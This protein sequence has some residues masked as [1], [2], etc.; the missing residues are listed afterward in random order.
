[1]G[2]IKKVFFLIVLAW[3]MCTTVQ[4]EDSKP[5][6]DV[7]MAMAVSEQQ[8]ISGQVYITNV[9]RNRGSF[10]ICVDNLSNVELQYLDIAIWSGENGQDDVIW[11]KVYQNS[12]GF[13]TEDSV[14]N[15]NYSIGKY[16]VHV[17]AVTMD[18]SY[19]WIGSEE[20]EMSGT[21][22]DPQVL[23]SVEQDSYEVSIDEIML[24]GGILEVR[25]AV[26]SKINGQDDIRWYKAE[27][28]NARY[29]LNWNVLDHRGLG[30]YEVH[31]Y[32]LTM[33]GE[34]VC[35]GKTSFM[36]S[37]PQIGNVAVSNL[38]ENKGTFKVELKNISN[39]S[40]IKEVQIAVWSDVN[41]QDDIQWYNMEYTQESQKTFNVDIRNHKY[42]LGKYFVHVYF[43]DI[44]GM[45]YFAGSTSCEFAARLGE[46]QIHEMEGTKFLVEIQ[47]CS[48]PGG[49]KRVEVPI[50]SDADGQDDLRWYAAQR[51]SDGS[52]KVEFD[53]KDHKGTGFYKVQAYIIT[54]GGE[55][56]LA[57]NSGVTVNAPSADANIENYDAEEGVFSVN[58]SGLTNEKIVNKILIPVWSEENGQD[59]IVWY[60]AKRKENGQYQVNIDIEKHRYCLGI[61]NIHVYLR[62][63]TNCDYFVKELQLNVEVTP[64]ELSVIKNNEKDYTIELKDF[65]IPGGAKQIQFPVWSKVNGQDDIKWHVADRGIDGIYRYH[66]SLQEHKGLGE[67]FIHSYAKLPNGTLVYLGK[68]G[69]NTSEPTIGNITTEVTD[70]EGGI[71]QIK[72][73]GIENEM[74]IDKVMVPVWSDSSQ[75]DIVWYEAVK[76][77][78][79]DYVVNVN[80]G[81]HKYNCAIYH[82]HVYLKDITG[83]EHLVDMLEC[84]MRP[85]YSSFVAEDP[86]GTE[87]AV[88]LT[89]S[90]LR[91]P[92]GEKYVSFAVW[93]TDNN[94]N[95]VRWYSASRNEEGAYIASIK[96]SNHK[97]LGQYIVHAYCG[98]RGNADYFIGATTFEIAK[99]P[100][101]AAVNV[102]DVNGT[103]G[104]FNVTVTG[105]M[106]P[107]GIS[108]VKVPVWCASDQSDIV[109]YDANKLTEGVYSIK[110]SAA[111]HAHHFGEYKIH[112]YITMGNGI[113]TLSGNA[114]TVMEA[115]NYVYNMRIS[116]TQRE[117]GIMGAS[118]E[119]VQFP[120]WS[121]ANGQDDIIWYEGEN[122]GGGKWNTA[123][124]SSRH[125]NGGEYLTHVYLTSGG[126]VSQVG[127]TSYSLSWLPNDQQQMILRS[128]L[129]S[130]STPFLLLVNR[131]THKVGIFQGWT[132]NWRLIQYWD[133]SDGKSST[134]TVEGVFRVGSRGYY[135]DSGD[136]R[137]YW[138]TQFYGDY[139][140]HS[141]LYNK[142]NGALMDGRLGMGLSHGCVRLDINNAKWIYDT[143]PSGSTVVVY[144]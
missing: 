47:G 135:F 50:W 80:I 66:L 52:Y 87:S 27:E 116:D 84:D 67:Y 51:C 20:L 115:D 14:S 138:W 16:F 31:A 125:N 53:I 73:S 106:A 76:N 70:Y 1:M 5:L 103:S 9:D 100:Y 85:S 75:K 40:L 43:N 134:P 128:N 41:G 89:L 94:Q 10:S 21:L 140:F 72:I 132:G 131:A 122:R 65:L 144:H 48:A 141:V 28:E 33:S 82:I 99:T 62:D 97:E 129:Y 124:D 45:Q 55:Y 69:F 108:K 139:L 101:V 12:T 57:I 36:I 113:T 59:D 81:R 109:W 93:G 61:Y 32:A 25:F 54:A 44:T 114:T 86:D 130:S 8:G 79:G 34:P 126:N 7:S 74:L 68:G 37:E 118:A 98:T 121:V 46:M 105:M 136:A 133:C 104:T 95:D 78:D 142:Y 90:G 18:G 107:S 77:F 64:G 29:F 26:W 3:I 58:I 23:E 88:L 123:I 111:R 120:T 143:I 22:A 112:V 71:F 92:A 137:C 83:E 110:V 2:K 4:A 19:A 15:H 60:V 13:W 6:P 42:S 127:S 117:V 39:S 17:Y 63:V 56:I 35:M 96:I 91:V 119:R 49:I 11:K 30:E 38:N 24:P 102:S